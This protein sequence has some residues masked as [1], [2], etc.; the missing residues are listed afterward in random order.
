MR[1]E[2]HVGGLSIA[3]KRTYLTASGWQ[4]VDGLWLLPDTGGDPLKLSRALHQQL[5]QD[6]IAALRPAG[7]SVEGYSLRGYAR[8]KDPS[9]GSF[10]SLPAALRRQARRENRRVAELTYSFYLAA[11]LSKAP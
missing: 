1:L 6:L 9:D 4:E 8:L 10:C 3:R 11:L 5:T 2:R 7:W